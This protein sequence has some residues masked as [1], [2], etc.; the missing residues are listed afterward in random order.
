MRTIEQIITIIHL[1]KHMA[2][3]EK[4]YR[5]SF[6]QETLSG[7]VKMSKVNKNYISFTGTLT[8]QLWDEEAQ[9]RSY[10][11][12]TNKPS[13]DGKPAQMCFCSFKCFEDY[14]KWKHKEHNE[15][16]KE[17]LMEEA[18]EALTRPRPTY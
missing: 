5:C 9:Y 3:E 15:R 13:D 14:A 1:G 2:Y 18:S 10:V 17:Q 16:R 12:I 11:Y 6:C 8:L 7:R 4:I